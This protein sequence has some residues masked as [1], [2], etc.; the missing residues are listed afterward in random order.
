MQAFTGCIVSRTPS[1]N[2]FVSLAHFIHPAGLTVIINP[3]IQVR[4][5]LGF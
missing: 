3:L 5:W 4:E 1:A 2:A